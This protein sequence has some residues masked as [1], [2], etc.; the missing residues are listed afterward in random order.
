MNQWL[1]LL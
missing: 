1:E